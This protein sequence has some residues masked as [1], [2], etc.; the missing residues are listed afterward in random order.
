MTTMITSDN[1]VNGHDSDSDND[2]DDNDDDNDNDNDDDNDDNDND[3]NNNVT[4]IVMI[5]IVYHLLTSQLTPVYPAKQ[6]HLY[7]P[8]DGLTHFALY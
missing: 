2:D 4:T 1:N 8:G 3:N 6:I 7:W 5:R